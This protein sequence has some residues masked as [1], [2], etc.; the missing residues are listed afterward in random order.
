MNRK[1]LI[2]IISGLTIA[3][4]SISAINLTN[5]RVI[6]RG[7]NETCTVVFNKEVNTFAL[8][9]SQAYHSWTATSSKETTFSVELYDN[10]A[11]TLT[12]GGESFFSCK[13]YFYDAYADGA[14][15]IFNCRGVKTLVIDAST[16]GII[17]G[18]INSDLQNVVCA[19]TE[20]E[21]QTV[22]LESD[23]EYPLFGAYVMLPKN[24]DGE[25]TINSI[26]LTYDVGE[27][28]EVING[29]NVN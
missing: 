11:M 22:T 6:T 10:Q 8:D 15:F 13:N 28:R 21:S 26:T 2:G 20:S 25:Y 19:V 18:G 1:L 4:T 17:V 27:C 23:N 5:K 29:F 16:T 3:A 14:K 9:E 12:C 7:E 24:P